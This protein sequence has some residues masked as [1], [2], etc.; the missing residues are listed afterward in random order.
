M[1]LLF[2]VTAVGASSTGLKDPNIH[3]IA[4]ATDMEKKL[5]ELSGGQLQEGANPYGML[6]M[7]DIVFNVITRCLELD[8]KTKQRHH[9]Q[10]DKYN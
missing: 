4:P 3:E 2:Q 8:R 10:V 7:L 5:H 6:K 1:I 9:L